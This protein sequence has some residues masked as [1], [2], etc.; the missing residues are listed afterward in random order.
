M[1]SL[2]APF[3]CSKIKLLI[4]SVLQPQ[5]G[6]KIVLAEIHQTYREQSIK[7]ASK[8][9]EEAFHKLSPVSELCMTICELAGVYRVQNNNASLFSRDS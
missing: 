3:N 6:V 9:A 1:V 4:M 8:W 5:C 2:D 7:T